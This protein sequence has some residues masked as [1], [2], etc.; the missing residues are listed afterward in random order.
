MCWSAGKTHKQGN[1]KNGASSHAVRLGVSLFLGQVLL[2]G[3]V[4][5][6]LLAATFLQG[7]FQIR[8]YVL[9]GSGFGD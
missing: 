4:C 6:L 2:G 3:G 5:C 9:Q 8:D 1:K 7:S